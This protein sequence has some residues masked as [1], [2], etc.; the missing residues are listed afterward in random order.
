MPGDQEPVLRPTAFASRPPRTG[1]ARPMGAFRFERRSLITGKTHPQTLPELLDPEV[2]PSGNVSNFE[3]AWDFQDGPTVWDEIV[4]DRA[5]IWRYGSLLP[6]TSES[7]KVTLGEG[8]TPLLRLRSGAEVT[9]HTDV[10]VKNES[11]NPTW[12]HKDRLAA[13][14]VSKALELGANGVAVASTGNHAAATAAYAARAGLPCYVFTTE[15]MPIPMKALIQSFGALVVSAADFE[16]RSSAMERS[17]RE[18]GWWPIGNVVYPPAGSNCYGI[19][20]YKTIAFELFEQFD[21]SVP[22]VVVVPSAYG[23]M[24]FGIYK[25]FRDLMDLGLIAHLPRIVAVE[26][27]GSLLESLEQGAEFPVTS[28]H[29]RPTAAFSTAAPTST[30]QALVALRESDGTAVAVRDEEAILRAQQDLASMDG[31]FVEAASATPIP[32]VRELRKQNWLEDDD[33]VVCILTS[34]GLKEPFTLSSRLG[35]IP[36]IDSTDPNH[37]RAVILDSYGRDCAQAHE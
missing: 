19:E 18:F 34:S 32:A 22:E 21:E 7:A 1:L 30:Y 20:G 36:R 5:G 29:V 26:P 10:Y 11:M 24:T 9:G 28:S 8:Q 14:G 35:P 6:V 31:L 23:D 3:I 33:R 37:V 17:V 2:D 16:T 27:F 15:S 13:A 12:S 25:G 4:S